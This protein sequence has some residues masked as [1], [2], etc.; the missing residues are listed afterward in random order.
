MRGLAGSHTKTRAMSPERV[1][2][3]ALPRMQ[4]GPGGSPLT[5]S[6]DAPSR[7]DR[8]PAG[9]GTAHSTTTRR[10]SMRPIRSQAFAS[11]SSAVSWRSSTRIST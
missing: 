5:T 2:D 1:I 10:P 9:C 6:G 7:Y 4:K 11:S 8:G 3:P